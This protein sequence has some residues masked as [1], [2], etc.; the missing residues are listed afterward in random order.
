MQE[1]NSPQVNSGPSNDFM[2]DYEILAQHYL[3]D[4]DLENCKIKHLSHA[5]TK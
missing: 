4:K 5:R 1:P 2:D 3:T